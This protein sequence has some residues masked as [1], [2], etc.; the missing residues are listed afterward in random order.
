MK[1]LKMFFK[2]KAGKRAL[3]TLLNSAMALLVAFL[4][5]IA[6]SN[7]FPEIVAQIITGVVLPIAQV[8][9]QALTK[10]LN[11]KVKEV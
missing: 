6:S 8:L 9:S 4:T 5:Y 7:V 11:P 10:H 2:S 3:W 1:F